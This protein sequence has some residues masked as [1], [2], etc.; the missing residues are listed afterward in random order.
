MHS[1]FLRLPFASS[2]L[3]ISVLIARSSKI[4]SSVLVI[5]S[6]FVKV[7]PF[8]LKRPGTEK[9]TGKDN[10]ETNEYRIIRET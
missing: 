5:S 4:F 3:I 7:V 8:R 2:S 1:H 10:D 9:S 6:K